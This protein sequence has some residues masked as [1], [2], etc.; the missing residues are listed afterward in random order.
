MYSLMNL[1]KLLYLLHRRV[2]S[3]YTE[4]TTKYHEVHDDI[5]F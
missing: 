2:N 5:D 1:P 4:F 3:R